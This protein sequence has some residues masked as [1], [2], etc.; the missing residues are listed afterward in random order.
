MYNHRSTKQRR[1]ILELFNRQEKHLAA[2][3]VHQLV[4]FQLP[5][6]SLGTVYRNLEALSEQGDLQKTVFPD[7]KARFEGAKHEH[8][9]HM[10]CLGCSNIVDISLCPVRP[11]MK[12]LL[13][14]EEFEAVYHRFEVFGYCRD[15]REKKNRN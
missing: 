6:I 14:A 3:E 4:R 9:H 10:V 7:G 15:C 11:E 13:N 2:E 1:A 12:D 5:K 8:H